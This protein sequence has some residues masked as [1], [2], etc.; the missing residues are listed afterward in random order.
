MRTAF[1]VVMAELM[2]LSLDQA[3]SVWLLPRPRPI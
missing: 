2:R 1:F 3:L